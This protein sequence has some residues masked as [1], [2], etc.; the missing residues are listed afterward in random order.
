MERAIGVPR[1]RLWGREQ[2]GPEPA[3]AF[4]NLGEDDGALSVPRRGEPDGWAGSGAR[5]PEHGQL[6][7]VVVKD[8][9]GCVVG[10]EL[11]P[12][13]RHSLLGPTSAL[14]AHVARGGVPA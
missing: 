4:A 11:E 13:D 2:M 8:R 9:S 1:P 14:D 5:T 6:K 3:L 7:P 12:V 10:C